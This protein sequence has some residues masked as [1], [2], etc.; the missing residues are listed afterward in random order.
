MTAITTTTQPA[1]ASALKQAII[2]HPLLAYFALAFAGTWGV[3]F[4]LWLSQDGLGLLPYTLPMVPAMLLFLVSVWAGPALAA[5]VVT[6]TESGSAGLRAF[7]RRYVHWR[8]GLRW[9]LVVLL[10]YPLLYVF[11]A[12]VFMGMAP[13]QALA[14][15]WILFFTAY[16]PTLLLVQ[17][18]TQWAKEPGWRG[19][20]LPRLQKRFGPVLGSLILGLL[21][22]L[23]HLPVFVY[24]G[25]PVPLGP[26]DPSTF[27]LNTALI[28]IMTISWTWVYNNSGGSILLAVLLHSSFNAS[29]SLIGQLIP[30]FP[31]EGRC[32]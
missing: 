3:Q 7:L 25:G 28:A 17:G 8:V 9:Y 13:M 10:A 22:G 32:W 16:L 5:F 19:F 15:K 1:S 20:A 6:T 12:T 11:A 21:H 2:R 29:G 14:E 24:T 26:F 30:A 23:W 31:H 4:P 27:A 18:L